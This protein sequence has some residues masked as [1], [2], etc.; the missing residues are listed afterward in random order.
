MLQLLTFNNFQVNNVFLFKSR[1]EHSSLVQALYH[2]IFLIKSGQ[3][4]SKM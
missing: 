3:D 4:E 2:V 1:F